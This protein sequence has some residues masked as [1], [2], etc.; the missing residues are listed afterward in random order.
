M[1]KKH[2][3]LRIH[4]LLDSGCSVAEVVAR[5]GSSVGTVYKYK[6]L[7]RQLQG[8]PQDAANEKLL[9]ELEPYKELIDTHIKRKKL[10]IKTLLFAVQQAGYNGAN[11][12][13]E[14]Y[15]TWRK[16]QLQP[17]RYMQHI[18]TG[19]GEQA[20]VDWGHFG[21]IL[22]NGKAEKVYLFAYI[23]GYSRS[24]YLEFV[25]RQNQRTLQTCHIHAFEAIGIPKTIVYDNMKTV[26]KKPQRTFADGT[27]DAILNP[28]FVEFARYYQFDIFASPPYWPRT[29][30]KVEATIKY[31]R[32][33]FSRVSTR[34]H[35]TLEE[36]NVR[37]KQW[38]S[39]QAH[40]RIHGTTHEKPSQ[41][42]LEEK[43]FLHFPTDVP[44]YNPAPLKTFFTTQYGLLVKDGITYNLGPKYARLKLEVRDI[45]D[46]GLPLIE[47]YRQNELVHSLQVPAKK[48]SWVNV[49]QTKT[50][51]EEPNEP[52]QKVVKRK[53]RA[54][55]IQVEERDLSHYA[56]PGLEERILY[57]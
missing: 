45:E 28:A 43:P 40:E 2:E 41:R 47:I 3:Q 49:E 14:H 36:L 38:V 13:V 33:F 39:E 34:Q 15:Y 8:K 6:R 7:G 50:N 31:V 51:E 57:G 27:G 11:S 54:Y 32:H 1:L 5:T 52:N 53:R 12:T 21:E 25:V 42:W 46:Y 24:V 4:D 44:H 55:E 56:V 18:E 16:Q 10:K 20:Q 48:H 17:D 23:L 30:G 26:V 9:A 29:K 22:I 37:L 19:K 35:I